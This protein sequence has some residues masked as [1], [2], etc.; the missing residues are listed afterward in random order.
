[1]F[2]SLPDDIRSIIYTQARKLARREAL[3]ICLKKRPLPVF[4]YATKQWE[5]RFNIT[6]C[7]VLE[8]SNHPLD[9]TP[10]TSILDFSHIR[11]E[12]CVTAKRVWMFRYC[13]AEYISLVGDCFVTC[14]T[15]WYEF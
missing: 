10:S 5:V 4:D 12:L 2:F 11:I 3:H 14:K 1:M 13:D 8:I 6:P 9:L 7:K 15:V